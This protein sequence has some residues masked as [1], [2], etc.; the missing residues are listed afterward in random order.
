MVEWSLVKGLYSL[1][2]KETGTELI[3]SSLDIGL[4]TPVYQWFP[5]G[6]RGDAAGY[7]FRERKIPKDE[8]T[9]GTVKKVKLITKNSLYTTVEFQYDIPGASEMA[10]Q[11]SFYQDLSH[12][13]MVVKMNKSN[14]TDPEGMYINFPVI[15][16]GGEWYLDKAGA[17]IRPGKDQ[18]PNTCC[19]YY[20]VQAGA[21][22]S[23][24]KEGVSITTLDAP[25][26]HV[27]AMRLWN[28]S[29]SIESGGSLYSWLTNN[30]WETNFKASCGGFYE[31]RYVLEVQ[32]EFSDNTKAIQRC[33]ENQYSFITIRK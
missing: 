12:F 4:G 19:D 15:T 28:Y 20:M 30:K 27:G 7:Q 11:Y 2:L 18:L 14:V 16:E 21:A 1:V 10:V 3:D 25:M 6:N 23:G 24:A 33:K 13:D 26:V 22:L 5:N 29:E 8:I 32:S 9:Y 31:F 17:P